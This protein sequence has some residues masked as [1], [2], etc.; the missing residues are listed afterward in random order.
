[1]ECYGDTLAWV[2]VIYVTRVSLLC[3]CFMC[4][5]SV[6]SS[7][8]PAYA[9]ASITNI[10]GFLCMDG[11]PTLESLIILCLVGKEVLV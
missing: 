2:G 10:Y 5:A 9:H 11:T 7:F 4:F 8:T 3:A 1:M 6:F